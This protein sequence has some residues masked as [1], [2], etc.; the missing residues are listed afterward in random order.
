VNSRERVLAA[1]NHQEPDRIPI[2]IG[3]SLVS[4]I[5]AGG[6]SRMSSTAAITSAS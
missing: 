5:M 1:I 4:G 2:D 3:G 6:L